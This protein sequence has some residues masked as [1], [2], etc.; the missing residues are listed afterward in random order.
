MIAIVKDSATP[1]Q[2]SHFVRWIED[3]GFK[4]NVS[5][6][7]NETIVGIIGDTTQIDPFL[8]ES[9]DII[10]QVRR[11]SEPFKKANRKFHP[12]DTVVDCGHGVL[13]GGG[14][15]QVIAGPCSVEGKG[16]ID[17]ARAV[18]RSGATMLRGGAYKPRTS[19]Y[20]YQG[21]G[22]KGLDIL[23]EASA[24]LD[25]PV[26]TE[27]MDPRD[28]Q[29]FL[30]KGIDVMQIGARNAQNFPLL[31]EVG[32]TRTPV[33]LKR[34]M[35]ETIDE[36]LMG[37]EYIMSEGNPNVILC[38]RGIRTFETRTRNTFDVNAIPVVH[39]LSHLPIIGD[40][41]HSTGY[42]RYVRPAAYAATAA[43]ADGLEIEVHDNPS[44]AW[45]DGAQALTPAQFDDAMRRIRV[46]REAICQDLSE[47]EVEA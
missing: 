37:A 23:L 31:R 41:S 44:Q 22:E 33:L 20:S 11:V 2:L 16:L 21:M 38:E 17:I 47:G 32:K 26:V 28:V 1:E 10:D 29:L 3:R 7:E 43:G 12:E 25:M 5:K 30:D 24:E 18:K 40:P 8:L 35:S 46:I 13:V 9:M 6:G 39:H 34:G 14:N 36:L 4:T 19:P 42:T 45:S 27:V 15:F